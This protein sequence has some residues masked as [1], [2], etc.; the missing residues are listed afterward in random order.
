MKLAFDAKR[1]THNG[2]GLGNYSRFIVNSLIDNY[3]GNSYHLYSPDKGKEHLRA[4]VPEQENVLYHYSQNNRLG[5]LSKSW[6]RSRGIISELKQEQFDLYHGLSNELPF[7]LEK[8]DIPTI[9]TIHDLIFIRYPQFYKPIDRCIYNFKFKKACQSANKII[10]VSEMTRQDILRMYKIPEE[11]VEVVYQGCDISFL[12]PAN[13]DLLQKVREKYHL[14][15]HFILNV[16]SIEQRKNLLLIVKA[17][18]LLNKDIH[19]IAIGRRT[20]YAVEVEQYIQENN[21]QEQVTLLNNI[22]FHE[23]PAFYQ[24]ASLFV[25]PSF[26]EGFGIPII[27][28]LHSSTPVIAATGSCLEEA[29]GPD[30]IYI[31][32]LNANDLSEKINWILT[33]PSQ[34]EHM[35]TAGKEY[36]KR[37]LAQ[38]ISK[39]V[40]NIYHKVTGA[41]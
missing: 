1:I 22:P 17:L 36:A 19:L 40:M 10:A 29:G 11:K 32:P 35:K 12:Q 15:E 16:G 28:A 3:P 31:S 41:V 5:A 24:L 4:L 8:T 26:F 27:E 30:S 38:T 23:L 21:M 37:F 7:G 6:W 39:D 13:T 20:P 14:P 2:T 25:Y 18:K 34:A 9:V 33:T